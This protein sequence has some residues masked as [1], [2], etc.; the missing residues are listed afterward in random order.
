MYADYFT[1]GCKTDGGLTVILVPRCEGLST[2][3]IKVSKPFRR[4]LVQLNDQRLTR[5]LSLPW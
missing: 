5:H 4:F 2:K 1:V 3:P